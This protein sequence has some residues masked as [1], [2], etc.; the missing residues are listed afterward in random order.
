[1]NIIGMGVQI[2]GLKGFRLVKVHCISY[3]AVCDVCI[4]VAIIISIVVG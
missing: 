2:C 1:M 3:V 4:S